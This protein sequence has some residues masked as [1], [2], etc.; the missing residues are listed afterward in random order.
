MKSKNNEMPWQ[1]RMHLANYFIIKSLEATNVD[2]NIR[3][4]FFLYIKY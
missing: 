2:F 4:I 1:T 3:Q